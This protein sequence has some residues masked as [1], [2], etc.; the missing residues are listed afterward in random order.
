MRFTVI[1]GRA[2]LEIVRDL[3]EYAFRDYRPEAASCS[4]RAL[5]KATERSAQASR[6]H[7]K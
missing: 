1:R 2:L 3:I 7:L 5:E 6:L 4:R